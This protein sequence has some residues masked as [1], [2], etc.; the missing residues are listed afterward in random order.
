MIARGSGNGR[1]ESTTG[2]FIVSYSAEYLRFRSD[3]IMLK[4]IQERTGGQRLNANSPADAVFGDRLPRSSTRP[5][6]D[7]L[8]ISLAILLPIDV[9][10]RRIHVDWALV[11]SLL[12][13]GDMNENQTTTLGSLLATKQETDAQLES[14]R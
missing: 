2:G 12:F 8:L 14:S 1:S 10:V 7:W 11:R 6:F 5:V 3:P 13:R 4:Q 9:A